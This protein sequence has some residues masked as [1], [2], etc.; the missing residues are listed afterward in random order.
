[1]HTD[2]LTAN[3]L[4]QAQT[5]YM[6]SQADA[7][8]SDAWDKR[9]QVYI[10]PEEKKHA[11]AFFIFNPMKRPLEA[12]VAKGAAYVETE[13]SGIQD[14]KIRLEELALSFGGDA[15]AP[16]A[17]VTSVVSREGWDLTSLITNFVTGVPVFKMEK[18]ESH[19]A[20]RQA[21]ETGL[22]KEL[23]DESGFLG[24]SRLSRLLEDGVPLGAESM[25]YLVGAFDLLSVTGKPTVKASDFWAPRT[26]RRRY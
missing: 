8:R 2:S 1:M 22:A 6:Q 18:V 7:M 25:A 20:L 14:Y 13:G 11:A 5:K 23:L 19:V 15:I 26:M 10:Y 17:K 16:I 3:R 12:V 4:L 9:L 21:R 24:G